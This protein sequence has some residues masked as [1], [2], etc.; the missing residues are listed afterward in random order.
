MRDLIQAIHHLRKGFLLL[1]GLQAAYLTPAQ[2][3]VCESASGF[4]LSMPP[5]AP[6]LSE[7][8]D[9]ATD[10]L[11]DLSLSWFS[12]IHTRSF[13][14]QISE[15]PDLSDP[16]IDQAGL[17][18][19]VYTASG[20]EHNTTYYWQVTSENVAGNGDP[21]ST[22]NFTTIVVIPEKPVLIEPE[23]QAK[24]IPLESALRW[25]SSENVESY[26]LQLTTASDFST[27]VINQ[28][29][30]SD[31]VYSIF[32]LEHD[33]TYYWKVRASNL[34]GD[35]LFSEIWSFT[36]TSATS[37]GKGGNAGMN[38]FSLNVYPNPFNSTARIE[39]Q[40]PEET[41]I[42]I[43]VYNSLGQAVR[44]LDAGL[45]PAGRYQLVWN[46]KDISG[47]QADGGVY[48]CLLK[49]GRGI[50]AQKMILIR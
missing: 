43:T 13:T 38:G 2:S 23:D 26:T 49:T 19:T 31:T 16:F 14:I 1:I 4:L 20:L 33:N 28:T 7:P 45:K 41:D 39:Y 35:G 34:A 12:Q 40:L 11:V 47:I 21:S 5:E 25:N 3:N 36:T 10:L 30:L 32:V 9:Q 44:L 50:V 42:L 29:D 48:V 18:D 17:S 24:D 22:W 15:S 27:L 8:A 37:L 6:V 46:G